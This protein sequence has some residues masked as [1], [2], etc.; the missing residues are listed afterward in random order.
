[1]NR[2]LARFAVCLLSVPVLATGALA[3][4][5]DAS[6]ELL[7][8]EHKTEKTREVKAKDLTLRIPESWKQQ[9]PTSSMRL[10]QFEIPAVKGDKDPG[11]LVFF[12]FRG[13]AGGVK[14]NLE[15]WINQF[16]AK[17][18]KVKLTKGKAT[19]GNY[20]LAEV[21]GAYN[22]S[23]GPPIRRQSKLV[24]GSKLVA[25]V[26]EVENA[27]YYIKL[28]GPEKTITSVATQFRASFG[29]KAKDEEKFELTDSL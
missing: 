5:E 4:L 8:S 24:P 9:R 19:Q 26:L 22:K 18:R 13:G 7:S 21:T 16:E 15:R 12:Y 27:K 20:Y 28:T 2:T 25:V 17:D 23:I 6:K 11:E 14:A 10:A 29:A 3:N 1:M